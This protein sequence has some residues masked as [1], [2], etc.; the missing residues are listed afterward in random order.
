MD[1]ESLLEMRARHAW[2]VQQRELKAKD[3]VFGKAVGLA[4]SLA[5]YWVFRE[6]FGNP[7][8]K[9]DYT[10]A[11]LIL[12]LGPLGMRWEDKRKKAE[13]IRDKRA[14]SI[15]AKLDALMDRHSDSMCEAKTF[16][17][18]VAEWSKPKR[19]PPPD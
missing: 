4:V 2:D 6:L 18:E 10:G 5:F 14:I 15:E 1:K 16:S 11:L 12:W 3:G 19:M 8:D 7:W 9:W 17:Q 13:E